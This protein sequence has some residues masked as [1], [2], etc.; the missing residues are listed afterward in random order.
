MQTAIDFVARCIAGQGLGVAT[1]A[2]S[3]ATQASND[4]GGVNFVQLTEEEYK[5]LETKNPTTFYLVTKDNKIILYF[6]G[7]SLAKSF[8]GTATLKS[9][10]Y[11]KQVYGNATYR[12]IGG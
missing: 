8:S 11:N 12:E 2:Q 9:G 1:Q 7:T 3:T 6:G 4:L 10:N 5:A